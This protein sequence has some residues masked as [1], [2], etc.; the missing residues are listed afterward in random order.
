MKKTLSIILC[1]ILC[2]L[3]ALPLAGCKG[4]LSYT[5]SALPEGEVGTAYS[6]LIA[7]ATGSDGITYSLKTGNS[8]PAGLVLSAGGTI[9]GTPSKAADAVQFTVVAQADGFKSAEAVFILTIK[10][11]EFTTHIFKACYVD[12]TDKQGGGWSY[13]PVGVGLI[14]QDMPNYDTGLGEFGAE[15][16]EGFEFNYFIGGT[17]FPGLFFDFVINSDTTGT[18]RLQVRLAND[19]QSDE[20]VVFTPDEL[21]IS[22]NGTVIKYAS[23]TTKNYKF[24]DFLV[25]EEIN[26]LEGENKITITIL[27]N[28]LVS[29]NLSTLGPLIDCIKIRT[30]AGLIWEPKLSNLGLLGD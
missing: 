18:G 2:V 14:Q 21:E 11:S 6:Q 16:N 7:T 17:W 19:L 10:D 4:A 13:N 20:D 28:E 12:L 3:L 9:S 5:G 8:L 22:V 24:E 1:S 29:A 23:F 25:A 15:K 26:L 27:E 30:Q